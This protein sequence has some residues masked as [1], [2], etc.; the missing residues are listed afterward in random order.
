LQIAKKKKK[1]L[2]NCKA[3]RKEGGKIKVRPFKKK[4]LRWCGNQ[5]AFP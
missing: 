5:S 3:V 1:K 4:A 2:E